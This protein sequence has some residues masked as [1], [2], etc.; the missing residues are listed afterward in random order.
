MVYLAVLATLKNEAPYI[1][2]WIEYHLLV[3]VELFYLYDNGSEDNL[4]EVLQPYIDKGLV[5]YEVWNGQYQQIAIYNSAIAKYKNSARW[6]AIIDADEFIVPVK[7]KTVSKFLKDYEAYPALLINWLVFDS[8]GHIKQPQG[9]VIEN[10]TKA[11]NEFT[12]YP[13]TGNLFVKSIVNPCQ[14]AS[15]GIHNHTY[16]N[17]SLA[18]T[19]NFETI[20]NAYY[21]KYHSINKIRINHYFSKSLEEFKAKTARG[22][23]HTV[24]NL[25][26]TKDKYI[27]SNYKHDYVI[28]KYLFS[29]KKRIGETVSFLSALKIGTKILLSFVCSWRNSQSN[30]KKQI[31]GLEL[32]T[33]AE[34]KYFDAGWYQ[35]TYLSQPLIFGR[36]KINREIFMSPAE[37]YYKI[38]W[39]LGYNPSRIFSTS[40]YLN[41]YLD[42]KNAKLNPLWHYEQ[43]GKSEGR[44]L[45]V[46]CN[47]FHDSISFAY[48]KRYNKLI[49]SQLEKLSEFY[50]C[51]NK[52]NL[53]DVIIHQSE[54][55]LLDSK[56]FNYQIFDVLNEAQPT[57]AFNLV[58]SGSGI[59]VKYWDYRRIIH[60]FNNQHLK[61]AIIL[62]SSFF[63]CDD[64]LNILDERF[65]VFCRE[66]RSYDYCC[67]KNSKAKFYLTDDMAFGLQNKFLNYQGFTTQQAEISKRIN[68]ALNSKAKVLGNGVRLIYSFRNDPERYFDTSD[69]E[70]FDLSGLLNS[71]CTD[72]SEVTSLA[73]LF[74]QAI[75]TI[76]ALVTDRLHIGIVGAI[77]GKR[78]LLLDNAYGKVAG[79]YQQS[80]SELKNVKL[81]S[82]ISELNKE[83]DFLRN[84][85]KTAKLTE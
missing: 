2:E 19:E 54:Y 77:L 13:P 1:K 71:S 70:S 47:K 39:E 80:M 74:I 35:K 83:F 60:I 29:L 3:G 51:P 37:H 69:F 42:V 10:Y 62:P 7:E 25:V 52:G 57:K 45:P 18:V 12:K 82:D 73:K 68:S 28:I 38:G 78:V 22:R 84:A 30:T 76:D 20:T 23:G 75:N 26:I 85:P 15:C 21:S 5:V 48:S 58:Y 66:K 14:V 34:S 53:S 8:N 79:V 27:F 59:F 43:W 81:L 11:L 64:L 31:D 33:I 24:P 46:L 36:R 49:C 65:V 40:L 17:A 72:K 4:K 56:K 50:F 16:Y 41:R 63:D 61:K 67:A 55:Q 44:V 6:I 9:L 32:K